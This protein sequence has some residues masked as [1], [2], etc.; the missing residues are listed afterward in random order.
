MDCRMGIPFLV[1]E[2]EI[3]LFTTTTL[4]TSMQDTQP[5]A[6]RYRTFLQGSNDESDTE[7][8]NVLNVFA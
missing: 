7:I 5:N 4:I 3:F 8:R 2:L 6:Q 1:G